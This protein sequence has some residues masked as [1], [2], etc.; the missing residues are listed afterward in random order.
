MLNILHMLHTDLLHLNLKKLLRD[1]IIIPTL[2]MRK[3]R[4]REVTEYIA[5]YCRGLSSGGEGKGDT[6]LL[7]FNRG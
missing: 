4:P 2:Q 3:L 6:Q 7:A 5:I 1:A